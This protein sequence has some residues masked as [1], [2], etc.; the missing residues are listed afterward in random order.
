MLNWPGKATWDPGHHRILITGA[1]NGYSSE[2]PTGAHSATLQMT[3]DGV[4]SKRWNPVGQNIAH[5]YD[6]NMSRPWGQKVY[7]RDYA[8]ERVWVCDLANNDSWAFFADLPGVGFGGQVPALDVHP[9][10]GAAGSLIFVGYSGRLVRY[11]LAT[12]EVTKLADTFAKVGTT[13]E[14]VAAYH[15]SLDAVVFGGGVAADGDTALYKIDNNGTTSLTSVVPN[16]VKGVTPNGYVATVF[17][18][19]PTGHALG[20]LFDPTTT[21]KVWQL[22]LVNG[23]WV[24]GGNLPTT[25]GAT[26]WL[27]AATIAELGVFVII[28]ADARVSTTKSN[29]RVWLYKP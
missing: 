10:L 17:L 15:P 18:P 19:D 21:R 29:S 13:A 11:D 24:D 7:R 26:G 27:T 14:T 8:T 12:K 25:F 16:G 1:S 5:I 22:D 4:F 20:W 28:D 6:S 9:N 2:S 23:T 3:A